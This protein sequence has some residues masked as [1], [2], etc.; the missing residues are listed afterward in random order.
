MKKVF[1]YIILQMSLMNCFS[2]EQFINLFADTVVIDKENVFCITLSSESCHLCYK[3]LNKF[4]QLD[5]HYPKSDFYIICIDRQE[6]ISSAMV[7]KYL[8]D[9]AKDYFPDI[10]NILFK[11][12]EDKQDKLFGYSFNI[13]NNPMV[14]H[15]SSVI[16]KYTYEEFIEKFLLN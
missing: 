14:F 12:I 1:V 10:E 4:L 7:R 2:Q 15:L 11:S 6:N 13:K 3:E 9:L 8:L 16:D 5:K